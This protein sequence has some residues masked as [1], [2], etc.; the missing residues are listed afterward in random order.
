MYGMIMA[1]L[2]LSIVCLLASWIIFRQAVR[3]LNLEKQ[4]KVGAETLGRERALW[5]ADFKKLKNENLDEG[6]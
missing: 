6:G 4:L 2:V 3:I 5:I 1:T